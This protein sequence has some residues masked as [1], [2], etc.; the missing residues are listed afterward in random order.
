LAAGSDCLIGQMFS[1][2][3][4]SDVHRLEARVGETQLQHDDA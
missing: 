2:W 3:L 4:K 1:D